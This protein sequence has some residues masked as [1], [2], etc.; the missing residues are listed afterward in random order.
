M[1]IWDALNHVTGRA[2]VRLHH[3]ERSGSL[4]MIA[5]QAIAQV[6]SM[7]LCLCVGSL[8]QITS[9]WT[10]CV[11]KRPEQCTRVRS[12]L[13]SFCCGER[14][15]RECFGGTACRRVAGGCVQ[16]EEVINCYGRLSPGELLRRFGISEGGPS[17][18]ECCEVGAQLL[19]RL[20]AYAVHALPASL[21][22]TC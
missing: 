10:V 7:R 6:C 19:L 16:G 2:N 18:H 4:Q 17:P 13:Y 8:R 11:S 14:Y 5:T 22:I 12:S 20:C 21:L 15:W 3:C 1:P 9:C